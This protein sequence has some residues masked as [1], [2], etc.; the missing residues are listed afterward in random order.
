MTDADIHFYFDPVCPFAWMTSNWVRMVQAECGYQVE[1]RFISLRLINASV[2]YDAHFPEGYEDGHTAG[3]RL[4]R[5]AA[6]LRAEHG[7]DR[8]GALNEALGARTFDTERSEPDRPADQG[9]RAYVAPVLAELAS[10]PV[11]QTRSTTP[12]STSSCAESP[13]RLSVDR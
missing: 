5:V 10:T 2:N 8:V 13:T 12:A 11:W 1:W 9:T 4:L 7:P 6:R 3:L